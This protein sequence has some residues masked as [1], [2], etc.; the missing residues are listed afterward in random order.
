[1]CGVTLPDELNSIYAHFDLLSDESTAKSAGPPEEQPLSVSI[2]DVK[3]SL[4]GGDMSK[5]AGPDNI[6]GCVLKSCTNQGAKVNIDIL[7]I[8][9][10]PEGVPVCFKTATIFFKSLHVRS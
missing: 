9:R 5:A 8:S 2:A 1:M 3:R 6:P 7:N 10:S 4:L